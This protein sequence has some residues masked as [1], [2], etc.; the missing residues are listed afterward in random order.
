[1]LTS[2]R[3][4]I[5][6]ALVGN[7]L[8]AMTK[9]LAAFMTGSSAMLSE[10]IHSAADTG[11]EI[12]LLYG[13]RRAKMPADKEFSFGHGKEIYFWSFV[14]AILL[15][16][17]GAG[18]SLYKG[19]DQLISPVPVRHSWVNYSVIGLALIFEG[20]SWYFALKAFDRSKGTWGYIQAVRR[21]KDPSIFIVLLED[22][23]AI[24]GLFVA[25]IGILLS[26]ITGSTVYDASASVIIGLI[27][28]GTAILLASET[29]GLLIGESANNEVVQ[30]I[31]EIACSSNEIK[32]V[33]EVLTIHMGP[34]FILVNISVDFVDPI[35]ATGVEATVAGLDRAIKRAYPQ[36]QRI[37]IEVETWRTK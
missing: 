30:G 26:H 14:V 8:I 16:A 22:S 12:L 37:F 31:R 23:A 24:I 15:F 34:D 10:A 11:N 35:L 4:V 20:I 27:L 18:L 1:M 25:L 28:A 6:I 19:I 32:H 29:K 33:N 5:Y 2:S 36:V 13:L 21:S 17:G 3:K 7:S 9:V